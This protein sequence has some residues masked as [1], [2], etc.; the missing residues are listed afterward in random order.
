M[1]PETDIRKIGA[2]E[3]VDELGRTS[4]A[5]L[6]EAVEPSKSRLVNVALLA[7]ALPEGEE[8][9][10]WMAQART[11]KELRHPNLVRVLDQGREGERLYLVEEHLTG[12]RLDRVL[13][14][15]RLSLPEALRVFKGLCSGLE[16]AHAKGLVHPDLNPAQVVVSE[17]LAVVKIRGFGLVRK[18]QS[19]TDGS[20]LATARMAFFGLHYMAPEQAKGG[21]AASVRGNIYSVG[22]LFYELLTGRL[23]RGRF[24]L[25]SQQNPEV[26]SELDPLVLKCVATDPE[27][28]FAT[29]AELRRRLT[30]LEDQLRLGLLHELQGLSRSTAKLLRRPAGDRRAGV[31]KIVVW[32]AI[33]VLLL[34]AAAALFLLQGAGG[35]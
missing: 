11:L 24:N 28:R 1:T 16:A 14:E 25:P 4:S 10:R 2:Y 8:E 35:G 13:A 26:P 27:D 18:P 17:D 6:Y 29:V 30:A 20:T 32:S 33:A 9:R 23:P 15:R 22:V 5:T 21:A 19:T 34:L 31:G 7:D 3:V 12:T